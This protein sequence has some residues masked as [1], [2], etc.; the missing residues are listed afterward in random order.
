[1]G[2]ATGGGTDTA[3]VTDT[4]AAIAVDIA[5]A[6]ADIAAAAAGAVVLAVVAE[7]AAGA[8]AGKRLEA[9]A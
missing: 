5:A 3:V 9:T 1:M 7:L 2:R 4:V 8:D 6:T